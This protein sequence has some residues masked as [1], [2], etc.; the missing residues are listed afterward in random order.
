MRRNK[1]STCFATSVKENNSESACRTYMHHMINF[2]VGANTRLK[3]GVFTL[4]LIEVLASLLRVR[5]DSLFFI[6]YLIRWTVQD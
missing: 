4:Q 3:V 6:T 1:V 2:Y 5:P